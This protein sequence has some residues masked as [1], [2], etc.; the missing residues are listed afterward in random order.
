ME[1]G[2]AARQE[3]MLPT[4]LQETGEA[5][6]HDYEREHQGSASDMKAGVAG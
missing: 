1:N 3:D 6:D 4:L 2:S 5:G